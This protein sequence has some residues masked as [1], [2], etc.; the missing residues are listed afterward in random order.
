MARATSVGLIFSVVEEIFKL[1]VDELYKED[2]KY[3]FEKP[4]LGSNGAL[5]FNATL[6]NLFWKPILSD[7][8][9]LGCDANT[10][11]VLSLGMFT[12]IP[13]LII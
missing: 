1:V 9:Y 10:V 7:V 3:R 6:F 8:A 2:W 5:V 13:P 11:L 4:W 12:T